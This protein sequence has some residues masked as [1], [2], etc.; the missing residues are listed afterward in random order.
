MAFSQGKK[1][2]IFNKGL[3]VESILEQNTIFSRIY[4]QKSFYAREGAP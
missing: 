3:L 2:L 1:L 4:P